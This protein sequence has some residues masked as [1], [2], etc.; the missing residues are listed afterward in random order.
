MLRFLRALLY[1][2]I[3]FT[4]ALASFLTAM[5]FAIHGSETKVPQL[6]GLTLSDAENAAQNSG[7]VL[8][9]TDR[10][11]SSAVPAGRVLSQT[12]PAGTTVRRG[13]RVQAALSLG[14]QTLAIPNF[15]GQS[16]RTA[17]LDARSHNLEPG[18]ISMLPAE[19][20]AAETVMAQFPPADAQEAASPRVNLLVAAAAPK[21]VFVMPDLVGMKLDAATQLVKAAGMV[22]GKVETEPGASVEP[23]SV[24]EQAPPPGSRIVTGGTVTLKASS[25][26]AR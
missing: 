2:L 8:A 25:T 21:A 4:V 6:R 18:V 26:G 13:F 23:A 14:P 5:R 19:D 17:E 11:F 10:F 7:L 15:V 3:L 9:G 1:T 20:A 24:V 22:L 12:P 16:E